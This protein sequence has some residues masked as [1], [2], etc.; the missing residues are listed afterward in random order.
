MG[1]CF[2]LLAFSS[3]NE[4]NMATLIVTEDWPAVVGVPEMVPLPFKVSPAGRDEPCIRDH[5]TV[6]PSATTASS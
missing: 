6:V 2:M 1:S 5:D 4:P 3:P